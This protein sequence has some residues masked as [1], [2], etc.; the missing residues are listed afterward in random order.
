MSNSKND[1][2]VIVV[3]ID[4]YS[5][6]VLIERKFYAFPKGSRKIGK[7]FAFYKK[8]PISAIT[9]Y[10]EVS[11]T[12]EGGKQ[13]VGIGYWL[14]CLPDAEPPFQIVRFKKIKKL[15][16]PVRKDNNLGRGKGHIQGRIYTTLSKLLKA[17]KIPELL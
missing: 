3:S 5:W 8:Y 14:N 9:H 16:F 4:N 10:G 13:E 6:K 2:K 11:K 1:E 7:Y 12:E 15:H 17:R